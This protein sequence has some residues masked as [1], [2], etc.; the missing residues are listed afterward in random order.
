[1]NFLAHALLSFSESEILTGNLISD[2]VKGRKKFEYALGIRHGISLHRS[3]DQFTDTHAATAKAKVFFKDFYGL[4][5]GAFIDVVYDHFLANDPTQ[6]QDEQHLNAFASHT[7]QQLEEYIPVCPQSF[8][9]IFRYMKNQ[10]WL[11]NYRFK[12]GIHNSLA[13][14]VRRARY[15]NDHKPAIDILEKNY[16]E[17][18]NCYDSFFP[19]VKHFAASE[20]NRLI[21]S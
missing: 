20:F 15:M 21:S 5:A 14:L 6:F 19:D 8:Q 11:Y 4:Y 2:F 17:L 7:Y 10:N 16:T 9:L 3:I 12:D 13:G 1:M 18:K